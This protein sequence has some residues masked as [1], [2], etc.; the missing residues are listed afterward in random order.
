MSTLFKNTITFSLDQQQLVQSTGGD[1]DEIMLRGS[2]IIFDS[3]LLFNGD[4][5]KF[6]SILPVMAEN[7]ITFKQMLRI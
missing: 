2:V 5:L 6:C 1:Y 4:I 7:Q 3:Y